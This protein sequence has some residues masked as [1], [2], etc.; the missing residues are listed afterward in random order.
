M[1]SFFSSVT[2]ASKRGGQALKAAKEKVRR[3]RLFAKTKQ[4][5]LK[6][7]EEMATLVNSTQRQLGRALSAGEERLRGY[8]KVARA[9]ALHLHET[10]KRLL[11][12]IRYWLRT[13][14]VAKD[15]IINLHIP[16]L[17]AIVRGKIGKT[18]EFGLQWGITRLRGGYLLAT[19]A[20]HRN[21]LAD[22]RFAVRAVRDHI[23]L[24]GEAPRAYAY[25]RAGHSQENVA[26]LKALGVKQ[27][28]LAP[29]GQTKWSVSGRVR[30][31]SEE[32]T[33][34]L[35][36]PCNLVCRLLLEKKKKQY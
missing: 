21:E 19:L 22:A 4:V 3:Y 31:R 12:Q 18:V 30:Q 27:V 29:R 6:L 11:P 10:M 13:G 25:D 20:K 34:E 23:Q 35:Q 5:R 33:S 9:K 24:F 8:S 32:H 28:A 14:W 2:A 16:E 26:E 36:S 1:A 17:Y 15:K 7:L